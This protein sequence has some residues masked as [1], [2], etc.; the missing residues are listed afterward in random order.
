MPCVKATSF[1]KLPRIQY[2]SSDTHIQTG[3]KKTRRHPA[4]IRRKSNNSLY[5]LSES[6]SIQFQYLLFKKTLPISVALGEYNIRQ[7]YS[8]GVDVWRWRF[9]FLNLGWYYKVSWLIP[10]RMCDTGRY[11]LYSTDD[12]LGYVVLTNN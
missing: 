1:S 2:P 12:R 6:I 5:T 3:Q 9:P 4:L 7:M 8:I 10:Q 11:R